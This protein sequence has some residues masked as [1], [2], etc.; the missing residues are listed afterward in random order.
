MDRE[1]IE[2]R[3]H[4]ISGLDLCDITLDELDALE[5]SGS[6]VGLDF[7]VSLFSLGIALSFCSSLLVLTIE[8]RKVF[9]TFMILTIVGFSLS[10]IFFIKWLRNRGDFSRLIQK[11]RDRQIGP[12]GDQGKEVKPSELATLQAVEPPKESAKE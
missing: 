4:R 2:I 1:Q 10:I 3:R 8:S 11:V 7:N 9:D 12:L 6:D 5:R